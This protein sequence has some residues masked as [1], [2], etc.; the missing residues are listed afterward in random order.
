MGLRINR[1]FLTARLVNDP[2]T[3]T[4]R[5][6]EALSFRVSDMASKKLPDGTWDND[7]SSFFDCTILQFDNH[8]LKLADLGKEM[9][10][11]GCEVFLEGQLKQERWEKDGEKRSR[12]M[13]EVFNFRTPKRDKTEDSYPQRQDVPPPPPSRRAPPAPRLPQIPDDEGSPFG[14]ADDI[15]F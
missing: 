4:F 14:S 12:V 8:T 1:F 7:A 6:G 9:L 2:E 5:G 13:L 3:R 10:S 15:P 11:K